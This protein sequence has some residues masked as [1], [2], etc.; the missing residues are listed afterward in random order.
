MKCS[1]RKGDLTQEACDVL[2]LNAFEG[3]KTFGG[4]TAD[5]D[6][7][8]NGL[9]SKVA[10]EERFTGKPESSLLF[11]THNLIP[12]KRVLLVGLG[13]KEDFCEE[14]VREASAIA[15]Q[16]ARDIR[17]KTI[18]SILHGAG[19]GKLPARQAAKAVVEGCLLGGYE[20]LKHKSKEQSQKNPLTIEL[21]T[22]NSKIFRQAQ[23]GVTLGEVFAKATNIA[24]D[25]VNEP[26]EH[27]SPAHLVESAKKMVQE[28]KG[29]ISIRVYDR[30]QLKKMG[31]EALL[32]VA[33]GSDQEPFL[34]HMIYKPAKA[35]K[36]VALVGKAIT[37]DSGGLSLKPPEFMETMKIDMAGAAAVIATMSTLPILKPS[38]EVHGIFGT[39]ENMPS[40]KAIRPGDVVQA[41]NKKTIEIFN[42]DAEGRV[43]LADSLSY[44]TKQKPDMIIDLATLT[45]A[46]MVALGEEIAGFMSNDKKM[47]ELI[48]K[49]AEQSGELLWE[50]PLEKRYRKLIE[51]SIADLNNVGK[52]RRKGGAITAG[53]FLQE[54]VDDIPW[55]HIDIAGPSF[56]ER[57]LNAYTKYGASGFGT[58]TLL[59]FLRNL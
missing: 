51:S 56:A 45:G 12:A 44:A 7:A 16:K 57:P 3:W 32:A 22:R 21:V 43:T 15:L 52:S 19:N 50:L 2:I 18:V 49:A 5:V 48:E 37:F 14:A 28:T 31:A 58:R 1:V 17:A 54:F 30:A 6:K 24:R 25:L 59:E 40:G 53:L 36:K 38:V 33:R 26:S 13:K 29:K 11:Y 4:A 8:L 41:M 10:Q 35:K 47:T 42:T 9:L 34:V 39:C 55:V 23:E 27:L 20:F 46:C